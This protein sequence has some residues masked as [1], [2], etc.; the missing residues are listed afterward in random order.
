MKIDIGLIKLS[1]PRNSLVIFWDSI[2]SFFITLMPVISQN[3]NLI[4]LSI[5]INPLE[6]GYYFGASRIYRAFNTLFG[7]FSQAFF[8]AI[9]AAQ[10]STKK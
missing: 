10:D 7:P 5:Y 6:L 1:S 3:I 9:S 8:P 2:Y 4:L